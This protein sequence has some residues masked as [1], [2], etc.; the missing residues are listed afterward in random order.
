MLNFFNNLRRDESGQDLIEYALV[1]ALIALGA[2]AAMTSLRTTLGNAFTAINTSL[3]T[4]LPYL[5]NARGQLAMCTK[6]FR[7]TESECFATDRRRSSGAAGPGV[8]VAIGSK[9]A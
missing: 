6:W 8:P 5:D 3:T 1:A 2:V 4:A 9:H 7:L